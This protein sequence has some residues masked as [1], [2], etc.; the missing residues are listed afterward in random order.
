MA[1]EVSSDSKVIT[2]ILE[3]QTLTD[4]RNRRVGARTGNQAGIA[5][6]NP[7]SGGLAQLVERLL[8]TEKVSGSNPLASKNQV[9]MSFRRGA[10]A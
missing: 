3:H 2:K 4:R 1:H 8:C 6:L 7:S 10:A 9:R 5:I